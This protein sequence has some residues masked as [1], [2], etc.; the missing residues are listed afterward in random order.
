MIPYCKMSAVNTIAR[1]IDWIKWVLL[2]AIILTCLSNHIGASPS[3]DHAEDSQSLDSRDDIPSTVYVANISPANKTLSDFEIEEVEGDD[4]ELH[5]KRTSLQTPVL[6]PVPDE[7]KN[8]YFPSR[9]EIKLFI[10]FHSWK[11]FLLEK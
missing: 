2:P 11:S 5:G 4:D 9:K 3:F 6:A 8:L 1:N 7:I 10:L